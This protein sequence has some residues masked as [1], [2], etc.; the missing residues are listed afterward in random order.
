MPAELENPRTPCGNSFKRAENKFKGLS[1]GSNLSL[2]ADGLWTF[3][4]AGADAKT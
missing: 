4:N 3:R 1:N 2:Y